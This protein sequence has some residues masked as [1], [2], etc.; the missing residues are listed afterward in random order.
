M[1]AQKQEKGAVIVEATIYFPLVLCTVMALIYLALFNMQGYMLMY[2]VQRVAAVA[3]REEAYL[4][5]EQF[6]M[7]ADQEIDFDW[8][9]AQGPSEAQVS[10]YY[11][12]HHVK[13][14]VLYREIG[15][16]LGII[17][18]AGSEAAGDYESRFADA[19]REASL[20]ALGT[21]SNSEVTI[22]YNLFRT[23]ITVEIEQSIP[24]PG[25]IK[26]LGID[27][28]GA[29]H[30]AAYTYSVNPSSFV[31]NV[32]LAVDLT[33]YVLDKLG[34]DYSGFVSNTKQVLEKIL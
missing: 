7:G 31:R 25:V 34:I 22:D 26:Y 30:T 21:M 10:A 14:S 20:V 12:A 15:D 6:G 8:G 17:T 23:E 27:N 13:A 16:V 9:E 5:Y 2:E 28:L 3:A 18:G 4:G 24:V 11:R 1:E 32:D 33:A 29:L 19:G